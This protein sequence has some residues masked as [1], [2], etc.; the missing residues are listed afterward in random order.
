VMAV[1]NVGETHLAVGAAPV[2]GL[3]LRMPEVP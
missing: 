2:P 3:P 1:P